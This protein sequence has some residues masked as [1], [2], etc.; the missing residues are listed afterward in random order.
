MGELLDTN[1]FLRLVSRNPLPRSVERALGRS[2]AE[3]FVSIVSAWEIGIKPQL[4][5]NP[6]DVES[7]IAAMGAQVLPIRFSHLTELSALTATEVIAHPLPCGRGSVTE[8]RA[9]AS[10]L[11]QTL[12]TPCIAKKV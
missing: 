4:G 10:G 7:G 11:P 8:P 6:F 12:M 1:V 3:C 2:G 9:Q 5:L